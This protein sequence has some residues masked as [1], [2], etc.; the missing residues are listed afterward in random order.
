MSRVRVT[1]DALVIRGLDP[2]ARRA[3]VEGLHAELSR[4]LSDPANRT[5]FVRS[6]RTSVMRLGQVPLEPG[7]AGGRKI[8][9]RIGQSLAVVRQSPGSKP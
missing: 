3:L 8:G 2:I 1:I 5:A 6:H 7:A 4:V 9:G